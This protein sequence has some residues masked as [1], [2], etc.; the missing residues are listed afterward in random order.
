MNRTTRDLNRST[1]LPHSFL[2]LSRPSCSALSS[3]LHQRS[4]SSSLVTTL[5]P[6]L[7]ACLVHSQPLQFTAQAPLHSSRP[8]E[9]DLLSSDTEPHAPHPLATTTHLTPIPNTPAR[10][11]QRIPLMSIEV[12]T[13]F[14]C[15]GRWSEPSCNGLR[16]PSLYLCNFLL[17]C[18]HGH[19]TDLPVT[20]LK[21]L[22]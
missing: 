21:N 10:R 20:E 8:F 2:P 13:L 11:D 1:R 5:Q 12:C 19:T 18:H 9:T 15:G 3:P 16:H 6:A 4:Q 14:L 7:D 22:W 17:Q